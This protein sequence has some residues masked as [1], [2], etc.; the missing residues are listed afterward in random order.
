MSVSV[1]V[2]MIVDVSK[3]MNVRVG[4][5]RANATVECGHEGK[6]MS[7]KALES[8]PARHDDDDEPIDLL[9]PSDGICAGVP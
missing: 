9:Q 8:M 2:S 4:M 5:M 7:V 3:R 1:S 6:R